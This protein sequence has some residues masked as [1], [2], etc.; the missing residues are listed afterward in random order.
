MIRRALSWLV[1]AGRKHPIVLWTVAAFGVF[2]AVTFIAGMVYQS[3]DD[4]PDR[5]AVAVDG[6]G[7]GESFSI[8]EYLDQGWS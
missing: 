4:D 6:G 5:G 8:P 2:V 1:D 7:Y 3:W